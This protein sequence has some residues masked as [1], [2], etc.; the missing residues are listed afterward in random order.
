MPIVFVFFTVFLYGQ[1]P[2]FIQLDEKDGLP[3]IEFYD[4]VEDKEGFIWLAAN[5]GLFRYDGKTFKNYTHPK[6]KGLS[7]FNLTF[8]SK[9]RLWFNTISGQ[10][11]FIKEDKAVLFLDLSEE[12]GGVFP[13]I[14]FYEN[15]LIVKMNLNISTI[16]LNTKKVTRITSKK[17]PLFGSFTANDSLFF[18][19]SQAVHTSPTTQYPSKNSYP[20][21]HLQKATL[22]FKQLP[23]ND[24]GASLLQ[25]YNTHTARA[26]Y[27][28]YSQKGTKLLTKKEF[29][30]PSQIITSFTEAN[31]VWFTTN[32]GIYVYA[33]TNGVLQYKEN[34]FPGH[35]I[36]KVIKDKNNNYWCTSLTQ[37]VFVIP[38]RHIRKHILHKKQHITALGKIKDSLLLYGNKEGEIYTYNPTNG[39][40]KM[41]NYTANSKVARLATNNEDTAL[42]SFDTDAIILKQTKNGWEYQQN[43][44]DFRNSKGLHFIDE[45]QFIFGGH[46]WAAIYNTSGDTI[47]NL[48]IKRTYT[49]HYIP[50]TKT[51]VVAY[52]DGVVAYNDTYQPKPITFKGK[53]ILSKDMDHTPNGT[54]WI[55][56][57]T[58][59]LLRVKNGIVTHNYTTAKGLL[60]NQTSLV[61]ADGMQLWVVSDLAIQQLNLKNQSFNNL[62]QKEGLS[63]AHVSELE[64][65]GEKV[66]LAT[67]DGLLEFDKNKAFKPDSLEDF[68]F[69]NVFI[70]DQA[71]DIKASYHL[72][73]N[74]RKVQLKFHSNGIY[75]DL[76]TRY[77]YRLLGGTDQWTTLE[78]DNNQI[79]FNNLPPGAYTFELKKV[80]LNSY[81]ESPTQ[82]IKIRINKPF[83]QRWWFLG[84]ASVLL[85]L[86]IRYFYLKKIREKENEKSLLVQRMANEKELVLL[87]LE[88]LRSQMNPH[89]VFNALNSIQDYILLNQKNLASNYLGKFA[90]LIR[91]YLY[92]SGKDT[93]TLEEEIDALK[94]YLE[95]EKLRFE[96]SFRY[97]IEVDRQIPIALIQIPTMLIQPYVENAI[98]HGLLHKKTNRRLTIVFAL[99]FNNTLLH[100]TITDNGVGR[101]KAQKFQK[102]RRKYHQAFATEA[103][104]KRIDLLNHGRLHKIQVVIS[105]RYDKDQNCKGTQVSLKIPI[106]SK[107]TTE[108]E[109]TNNR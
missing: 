79:T 89:F 55:S 36:T 52:V 8:D 61:K 29:D 12:T 102:N 92:Q 40:H 86:I 87:K 97:R 62:S 22:E 46:Q 51:T 5:N 70:N 98:K 42:V 24:Q 20:L 67:R 83:Y 91:V 34:L 85:L 53:P 96:H 6:Q 19:S 106:L 104:Q 107:T 99:K 50:Q 18:V 39:K 30:I 23:L 108:H 95:L 93:I 90:D 63:Y 69:T 38:N 25:F 109:S 1:H 16:D 45:E 71:V 33:Y 59:G 31:E 10:F 37:G 15:C 82:S 9:G 73:H 100:C 58:D 88:N 80:S 56:T 27:V 101:K 4:V 75:A 76:N 11:F 72:K 48:G 35:T 94:Q 2:L 14:S 105:D 17:L 44:N 13:E 7:V 21:S 66:F 28:H 81:Q 60:S 54:L 103:N 26:E 68:Y 57:F 3:D 49:A 77:Q 43:H 74:T 41:L 32:S 65:L 47:A 64:I 84:L 78:Q